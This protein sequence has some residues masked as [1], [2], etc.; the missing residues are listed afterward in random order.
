MILGIVT[1]GQSP[2]DDI[3]AQFAA[4]TPTGTKV[5]LRG[6]LDGLTDDEIAAHPPDND[7]DTLYTRLRGERDVKISK[8]FIIARS[9]AVLKTLRSDDRCEAIVYACTGEFPPMVGDA[10]VLFPSRLLNGLSAALLPQGTLGLLLP[11]PEQAGKLM[12][13]WSRPGLRVVAEALI[14]SADAT[15]AAV[16]AAR[17]KDKKPDLVAMDCM[18]YTPVTKATVK[19]VLGVPT[20]LGITATARMLNEM[21]T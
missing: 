7:A 19:D 9:P 20:I 11:L 3:A 5:V 8:N 10:G 1:I 17:L 4:H 12:A 2:R 13:K 16:A 6:A 14:P 21:L 18:S 15:E